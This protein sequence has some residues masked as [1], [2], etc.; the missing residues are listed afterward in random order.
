M[1]SGS[2]RRVGGGSIHSRITIN[3]I[4]CANDRGNKVERSSVEVYYA[5]SSC[6]L[7]VGPGSHT[8][9]ISER[10]ITSHVTVVEL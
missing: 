9:S 4:M 5:S 6:M 3:G 2:S 7:A 10:V 8:V 1:A